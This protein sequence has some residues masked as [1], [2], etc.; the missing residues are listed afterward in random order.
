MSEIKP[1]YTDEDLAHALQEIDELWEARPGTKDGDRLHILTVLVEDY[2]DRHHSI[3]LPDPIEAI[4][5]RLED[6]NIPLKVNHPFLLELFGKPSKVSEVLNRR[7]PLSIGMIRRIHAKL[8]ISLEILVQEFALVRAPSRSLQSGLSGKTMASAMVAKKA[9]TRPAASP[10]KDKKA[11]NEDK[12]R[13]GYSK[14]PK[15]AKPGDGYRRVGSDLPKAASHEG[16]PIKGVVRQGDA[17]AFVTKTGK[18]LA[19]KKGKGSR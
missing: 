5:V 1:I 8:G 9:P 13:S 6:R 2:E 10:P 11:K 14:P 19:K 4:K 16:K 3:P 17:V 7:R 15:A 18:Q 12:G